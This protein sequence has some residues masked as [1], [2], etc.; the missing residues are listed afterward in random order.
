MRSDRETSDARRYDSRTITIKFIWFAAVGA[1]A[2]GIQ[3]IVLVLS[4]Q[5]LDTDP[6]LASTVGFVMSSGI[7]YLLNY[8]LTFR[9]RMGHAH[10]AAKFVVI[11]LLGLT[12]NWLMMY[13]GVRL[14]G[15]HYLLTQ[16]AATALV[17][18]W[19][20]TGNYVW[21]F[22]EHHGASAHHGR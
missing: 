12:L 9:S 19:N 6:V 10:T 5:L 17:L 11:S 3:Y 20:F 22:R 14:L 16:L 21:S 4:V 2:T 13:L 1:V 18:I 15:F 8:H 7:N